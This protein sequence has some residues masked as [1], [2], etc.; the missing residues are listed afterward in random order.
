[1]PDTFQSD[2]V[3]QLLSDTRKKKCETLLKA[4][5]IRN[6]P[7]PHIRNTSKNCLDNLGFAFILA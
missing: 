2:I 3:P 6:V 4:I 7:I 5:D 1:M